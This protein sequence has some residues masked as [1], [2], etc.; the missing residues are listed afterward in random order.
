MIIYLKKSNTNKI[1]NDILINSYYLHGVLFL[2]YSG[3]ILILMY[4]INFIGHV[5]SLIIS[6]L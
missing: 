3:S 2:K 1:G 4:A 5:S 6:Q